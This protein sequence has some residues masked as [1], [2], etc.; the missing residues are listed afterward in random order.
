MYFTVGVQNLDGF[1]GSL[2]V[3]DIKDSQSKLY[4]KDLPE[5]VI[6]ISDWT[7]RPGEQYL[8]GFNN[9]DIGTLPDS[10]LINGRAPN[11]VSADSTFLLTYKISTGQTIVTNKKL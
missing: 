6:F 10:F 7:N 8:P 3:R 4:D 1:A 9:P 2:I 11:W 5:H